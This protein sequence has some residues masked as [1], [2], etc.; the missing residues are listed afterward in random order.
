MEDEEKETKDTQ[1]YACKVIFDAEGEDARILGTT[2]KKVD[3]TKLC[4]S[5]NGNIM[6]VTLKDKGDLWA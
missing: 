2:V 4:I 1:E 3:V 5:R 6:G